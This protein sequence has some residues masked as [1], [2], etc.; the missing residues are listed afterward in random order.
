MKL[1]FTTLLAAAAFS[2]TARSQLIF[3]APYQTPQ[4]LGVGLFQDQDGAVSR[5]NTGFP[6]T[7]FPSVSRDGRFITLTAPDPVVNQTIPPSSAIYRHDRA[8]GN[9]TRVFQTKNEGTPV[10]YC[11]Q[12]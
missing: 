8:T 6:D 12:Y 2:T 11:L 7:I 4:G 9:T 1:L 5:I 10:T 3:S